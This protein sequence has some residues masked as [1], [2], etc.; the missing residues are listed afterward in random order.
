MQ[1][2]YKECSR[3]T[4]DYIILK[5]Y[6][7]TEFRLDSCALCTTTEGARNGTQMD[8]ITRTLG[9]CTTQ[10]QCDG[11]VQE[12]TAAHQRS[13]LVRQHPESP[14]RGLCP[15]LQFTTT[16]QRPVPPGT[17]SAHQARGHYP[18]YE[19]SYRDLSHPLWH[20]EG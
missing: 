6:N 3:I 19:S 14:N 18:G 20:P 4:I 11:T 9:G 15:S 12:R 10:F 16:A 13:A 2:I 17:Q 8:T 1:H 5:C 7:H